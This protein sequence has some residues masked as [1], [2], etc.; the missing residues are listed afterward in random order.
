MYSIS[1]CHE[2]G[3]RF[4]D[5]V[6]LVQHPKYCP[7]GHASSEVDAYMLD[8]D[9]NTVAAGEQGELW[10]GGPLLAHG[11]LNRAELTAQRF[12][13]DRFS[14]APG[15]RMY[16]TGDSARMLSNGVIEILGRKDFMVKIRGYSVVLGAIESALVKTV[17]LSSC[18]V[19]ASGAEGEDKK[20]VAFIVRAHADQTGGRLEGF[21]V[22]EG[23]GFCPAI[24]TV[25]EDELTHYSIPSVFV[26]V[27]ALPISGVGKVDRKKL[28]ETMASLIVEPSA[29]GGTSSAVDATMLKKRSKQLAK[30]MVV[31]RDTALE[32]V[33]AA[34]L[35]LWEVCLSVDCG[36]LVETDDFHALG[37]HSLSAAALLALVKKVFGVRLPASAL[38]KGKG[39]A[40]TPAAV[41]E[42]VVDA[43]A[44]TSDVA[45]T[46]SSTA[47]AAS[48]SA[49]GSDVSSV[50][51]T[52]ALASVMDAD[53][54]LDAK[55]DYSKCKKTV[56][57]FTNCKTI[58]LT[59]G[60]GFLGAYLIEQL[61]ALTTTS[62][63]C[64]VRSRGG[65][66]VD[67]QSAL[68]VAAL[69]SNLAKY[70][71][72]ASF[73]DRVSA[74]IGDLS[75]EN[76]GLS[77]TQYSTLTASVDGILHSGA[78]VSLVAPYEQLKAINV[79][80]TKNVLQ[81]AALCE[82]GASLMYVSTN[83][84][85]PSAG[86]RTIYKESIDLESLR[87]SLAVDDGYGRSKL[88]A[89]Q[90]VQAAQQ[91]GLPCIIVRPGNISW[92]SENGMGNKLDYQTM[93]MSGSIKVGAWPKLNAPW[94]LEMSSV[95]WVSKC[96]VSLACGTANL[97][98][99]GSRF[100][101]TNPSPVSSNH[102]HQFLAAAGY[103]LELV[104]YDEWI[105]KVETGAAAVDFS[106][107]SVLSQLAAMMPTLPGGVEYL[108]LQ[109]SYDCSELDA[110]VAALPEA[111]KFA[112]R[113]TVDLKLVKTW[114]TSAAASGEQA[115]NS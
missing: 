27:D 73:A 40:S 67:E 97:V 84:I 76:F 88:V 82:N 21:T 17:A 78:A 83:G 20:L 66:T 54:V 74:V 52:K 12:M 18:V 108:T 87:G 95:D 48:S 49:I 64:L 42:S 107:L 55:W 89:E 35:T 45:E 44:A 56:T 57:G 75:A 16:R 96:I 94:N 101:L 34:M 51:E 104:T 6:D 80:G 72:E 33:L 65:E 71:L 31:P 69:Q 11:Y 25:L 112:A 70:G 50:E 36:N 22:E 30:Y 91:N 37:G 68:G 7:V 60:T 115:L 2:V 5:E 58:F 62:I 114:L 13:A 105:A 47:F 4:L 32:D 23:S 86:S 77:D 9:F 8:D 90:L 3:C 99:G 100:N 10:I 61:L 29:A 93:I 102:V 98:D 28:R 41:C 109:P 81:L 111:L 106:K 85:F 1:E 110:A 14:S 63:L 19:I 39:K 24:R 43:W 46:K 113:P 38:F 79:N 59:G 26:E 15:A 92:H 103:D 53:A